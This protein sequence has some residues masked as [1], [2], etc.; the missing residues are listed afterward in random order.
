[1][2]SILERFNIKDFFKKK[3]NFDNNF[4]YNNLNFNKN[5]EFF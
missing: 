2:L 5:L 4:N 3:L 1:M